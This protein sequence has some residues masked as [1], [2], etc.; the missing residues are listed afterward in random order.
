MRPLRPRTRKVRPV[1][2]GVIL[3]VGVGAAVGLRAG[4]DVVLVRIV[5]DAID[6]RAFFIARVVLRDQVT[7]A[8]EIERVSV[9]LLEVS[10]DLRAGRAVPGSL[11]G[12]V[13]GVP[14]G[15]AA[16]V[17]RA[18]IPALSGIPSPRRGGELLA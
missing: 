6:Q 7:D 12:A 10:S 3:P 15:S 18:E 17:R 1:L 16:R 5:A 14:A 9:E 8:G 13:A 4:Q 2:A 11:A